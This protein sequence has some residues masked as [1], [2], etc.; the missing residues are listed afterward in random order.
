MAYNIQYHTCTFPPGIKR[1]GRKSRADIQIGNTENKRRYGRKIA[2]FLFNYRI[3][4]QT[5][6]GLSPAEMLM[7]RRLHSTLELL[8]PN[9][10]SKIRKRKLK[11]KEQHKAHSKWRSFFPGDDVY[12]HNYSY[13][14]KWIPA[15]VQQNTGPV[16]YTVQTGD[17]RVM[18]CHVNQIRRCHAT[19]TNEMSKPEVT[20]KPTTLQDP[21]QAVEALPVDSK[22]LLQGKSL[23]L[24]KQLRFT[25]QT[26]Q[27]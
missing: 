9:V 21:E 10:K 13:R 23:I 27:T 19:M 25:L 8:L 3:T 4:P 2:R 15:V 24:L 20:E 12:I 1:S 14:P 22:S 17:E 26:H 5:T 11:Q 6:T 7:S 16:P 18:R